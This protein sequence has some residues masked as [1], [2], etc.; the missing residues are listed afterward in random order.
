[1]LLDVGVA[2]ELAVGA[3]RT[4][5]LV[6]TIELHYTCTGMVYDTP[7]ISMVVVMAQSCLR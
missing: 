4:V 3:V 1:M 2:T 7:S 5:H 6:P